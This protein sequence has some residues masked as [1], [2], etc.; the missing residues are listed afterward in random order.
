MVIVAV[1]TTVERN[2]EMGILGL[3]FSDGIAANCL[4]PPPGDDEIFVTL[5]KGG[6][7]SLVPGGTNAVGILCN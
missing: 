7:D 2:E 3:G 1:V 5:A 6:A 4:T